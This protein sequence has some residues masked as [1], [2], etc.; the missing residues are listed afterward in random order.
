[1]FKNIVY[2]VVSMWLPSVA[3]HIFPFIS[4][5]LLTM[6]LCLFKRKCVKARKEILNLG[7]LGAIFA[8]ELVNS[9]LSCGSIGIRV[10]EWCPWFVCLLDINF[11]EIVHFVVVINWLTYG[12]LI[13]VWHPN[14]SI[15][16]ILFSIHI[17]VCC[18]GE[19]LTIKTFFSWWLFPLFLLL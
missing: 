12:H 5:T 2:Q 8:T 13:D 7:S 11:H 17:L 14:I 16:S 1:M 9:S 18:W 6:A 19:F 15:F 3:L 4:I 10:F